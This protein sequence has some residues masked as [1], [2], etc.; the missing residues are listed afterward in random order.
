MSTRH[1]LF[2][3]SVISF[4]LLALLGQNAFADSIDLSGLGVTTSQHDEISEGMQ[5]FAGSLL[6]AIPEATTQNNVWADA[7]I[8][9]LFPSLIPH[10]GAGFS[11]GLTQLDMSGL[12]TAADTLVSDYNSLSSLTTITDTLGIT[13]FS[14]ESISFTIPETFFLPSLSLDLRIGGVLLPFDIGIC[15]MMTNPNLSAIDTSDPTT[16]T[17]ASSG[18]DFDLSGFKGTVNYMVLGADIR[19]CIYEGNIILPKISVGGGYYYAKGSFGF[20]S[21][22]EDETTVANVGVSYDSHIVFAQIEASKNFAIATLFGGLRGVLNSTNVAW[23][24]DYTTDVEVSGV[25]YTISDSDSGTESL[26]T[27]DTSYISTIQPQVYLG[28]GFN[29]LIFQTAFNVCTDLKSVCT[30]V[31]NQSISELSWSGSLSFHA[32]L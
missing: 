19:Y 9:K 23:S 1:S 5:S 13:D 16:L 30:A 32:K 29:F 7:Y 10:I 15:A 2:K 6:T 28:A 18:I 8:G 25:T 14:L 26:D 27:L 21:G 31:Q 4:S 11:F 22:N 3:V 12:K 17:N 20:T 24:W